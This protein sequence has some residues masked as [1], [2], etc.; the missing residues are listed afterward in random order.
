MIKL[1][2]SLLLLFVTGSA[3]RALVA[4][5]C[6]FHYGSKYNMWVNFGGKGKLLQH[7]YRGV[8]LPHLISTLEARII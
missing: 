8:Y 6:D 1:K 4:Q 7:S 3:K 2:C 5:P